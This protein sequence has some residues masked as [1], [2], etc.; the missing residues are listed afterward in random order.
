MYFCVDYLVGSPVIAI[1]YWKNF[2]IT[3]DN[4]FVYTVYA[5]GCFFPESFRI[6]NLI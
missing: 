5:Y 1:N 4:I 6:P 3:T 2:W